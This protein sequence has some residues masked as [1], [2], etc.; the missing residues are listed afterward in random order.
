MRAHKALDIIGTTFAAANPQEDD[1]VG[2]P[3]YYSSFLDKDGKNLT[4]WAEF[5][6]P[7]KIHSDNMTNMVRSSPSKK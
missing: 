2:S 1:I 6:G 5:Y 7:Q 4:S 3:F